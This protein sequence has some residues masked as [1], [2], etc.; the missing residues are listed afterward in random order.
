MTSLF[1]NLWKRGTCGFHKIAIWRFDGAWLHSFFSLKDC[2]N[3]IKSSPILEFW[4]LT[5]FLGKFQNFSTNLLWKRIWLIK[6]SKVHVIQTCVSLYLNCS[7]IWYTPRSLINHV[8]FRFLQFLVAFFEISD[9][10]LCHWHSPQN[11]R[12]TFYIEA[13]LRLSFNHH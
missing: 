13:L 5:K 12:T 4:I 6:Q 10:R 2:E 7:S 11:T 9:K 8:L 1:C 3:R